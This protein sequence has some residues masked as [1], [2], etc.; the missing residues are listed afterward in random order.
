MIN[1]RLTYRCKKVVLV[2]E[3]HLH[4]KHKV[5]IGGIKCIYL[6]KIM[7][8]VYGSSVFQF[9][10]RMSDAYCTKPKTPKRARCKIDFDDIIVWT[11]ATSTWTSFRP[12]CKMFVD[13]LCTRALPFRVIEQFLQLTTKVLHKTHI[14]ICISVNRCVHNEIKSGLTWLDLTL[15]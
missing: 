2:A 13:R 11:L 12:T 3:K 9:S 15:R 8:I 4:H 7:K 1:E 5:K 6:N 10:Y 14:R